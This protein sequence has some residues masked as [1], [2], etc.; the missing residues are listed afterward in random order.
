MDYDWP[1][2]NHFSYVSYF[3]WIDT[4]FSFKTHSYGFCYQATA[5]RLFGMRPGMC[6]RTSRGT[7]RVIGAANGF[8]WYQ[9]EGDQV[10]IPI[11]LAPQTH[12]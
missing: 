8:L 3:F 4:K 11:I 2:V 10:C 5:C 7:A 6:V 1:R 12:A 9:L